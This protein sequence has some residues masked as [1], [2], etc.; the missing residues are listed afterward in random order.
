M[1]FS[2]LEEPDLEFANGGTHVDI[3]F[4]IATHGPLDLGDPKAPVQLRV[5]VVG[6]DETIASSRQWLERCK[7]GVPRKDSKLANLFPAFPGFTPDTAFRSSLVFHDRWSSSI[8][9]REIDAVLAHSDG[10]E[11][12]RQSVAMFVDRAEELVQQGGPMVLICVPPHD[13]LAAVDERRGAP[14][15]ADE[16]EIDEGSES[17]DSHQPPTISFHDLLKAEGMRLSVP[18]QMVRPKTLRG[19]AAPPEEGCAKAINAA[20]G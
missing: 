6:T 12:V 10:D 17:A 2:F 16:Q 20:A 9:Q 11:T 8:R 14:V 1:K 4:G 3:R 18:I 5:G 7:T 13:L 19:K 15:D